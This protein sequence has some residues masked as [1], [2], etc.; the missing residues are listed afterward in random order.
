MDKPQ[1]KWWD[2]MPTAPEHPIK[3][4][5]EISTKKFQTAKDKYES[6]CAIYEQKKL[7]EHN[8]KWMR[9]L[10]SSGTFSDKIKAL[11]LIVQSGPFNT[12]N[13]L[14]QLMGHCNKKNKD[15]SELAI[16]ATK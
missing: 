7:Q 1:T 11:A 8:G 9:S 3:N 13:Y 14:I 2:D 12:Y 15:E 10:I 6:M 16:R 4:D 5:I